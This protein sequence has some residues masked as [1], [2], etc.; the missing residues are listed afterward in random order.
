MKNHPIKIKKSWLTKKVMEQIYDLN[1]WGENDSEFYSE[2]GS[3]NPE[4]VNP[5][6]NGVKEFLTLFKNPITVCDL[7]CGYFNIGSQLVQYTQ[8]YIAVDIVSD[9][10]AYNKEKL[11]ADNLEL[12]CL[13]L[14]VD[15]L[16]SADC[17]LVRQV[18]QHLSNA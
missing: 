16:P 3:H 7:G 13:D 5:Y 4:I 12:I 2:F 1:L 11:K 15:D 9:L 17:A 6:I 14:A 8:K 18:L 10:I